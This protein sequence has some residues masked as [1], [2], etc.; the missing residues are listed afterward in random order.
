MHASI[1]AAVSPSVTRHKVSQSLGENGLDEGAQPPVAHCQ[2]H[3]RQGDKDDVG[4]TSDDEQKLRRGAT[5]VVE[6]VDGDN[7]GSP[8]GDEEHDEGEDHLKK[9]TREIT[10]ER[11]KI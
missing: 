10:I 11:I 7:A 9:Y 6:V 1:F 2:D 8:R 5:V 4:K 3:W